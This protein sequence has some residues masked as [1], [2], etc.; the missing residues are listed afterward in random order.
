[1]GQGGVGAGMSGIG[2]LGPNSHDQ[3]YVSGGESHTQKRQLLAWVGR[4]IPVPGAV[5][6]LGGETG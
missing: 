3:T 6:G 4:E 2:I 1:M 5:V